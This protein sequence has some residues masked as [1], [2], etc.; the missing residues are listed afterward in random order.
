MS[1]N[2]SDPFILYVDDNAPYDP[3]PGDPNL[4]DPLEDGSLDHPYDSIQEAIDCAPT[5][6]HIRVGAGTYR[7]T[8]DFLGKPLV[9]TGADINE[10]I[11]RYPLLMGMGSGPL[12]RFDKGETATSR[13][14]GFVISGGQSDLAGAV[15]CSGSSPVVA[16]CLIVGNRVTQPEQGA[17]VVCYNSEATLQNCTVADNLGGLTLV[18]SAVRVVD[19][20]IWGNARHDLLRLGTDLTEFHYCD[21]VGVDGN[22]GNFSTDPCFV[23]PGYWVDP[24]DDTRIVSPTVAAAQWCAGDYHLQSESGHWSPGQRTWILDIH[25]SPCIDRGSPHRSFE[26]ESLPHGDRVNLG[27]YGNTAAASR[28]CP[29]DDVPVWFGNQA[30]QSAVEET[31]WVSDPTPSDMLALTDLRCTFKNVDDITGL[32][33]ALNLQTLILSDNFIPDISVLAGLT[34]LDMLILNQ[35]LIR[36]FSVLN[37]LP[38]LRHLD[39]HRNRVSDLT[40]IVGL[41]NLE[42]L[43]IRENDIEDISQLVN[44]TKLRVLSL[45]H[46][47]VEDITPLAQMPLLRE[48]NLFDCMIADVSPLLKFDQLTFLDLRYNRLS[49]ESINKHIPKIIKR[50]PHATIKWQP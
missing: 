46:N 30:I 38:Q 35:N 43:I 26:A 15:F 31:L 37:R 1:A 27:A 28:T 12:V 19:S 13:L 48:I 33:Y 9:V 34:K 50:N 24:N 25:S 49:S 3:G 4:S 32:E 22:L 44:L 40:N 2:P 6:S 21:I 17:A 41:P 42:V 16:H 14:D 18:D 29:L 47:P 7:E 11:A 23:R 39:I 5:G 45:K 36:D 20:I 10:P 8:L